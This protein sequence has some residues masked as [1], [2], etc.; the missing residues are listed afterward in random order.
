MFP[1]S[2]RENSIKLLWKKNK[3]KKG[4]ILYI[5]SIKRYI[6]IKYN[7]S[8]NIK[9]EREN[10]GAEA[11]LCTYITESSLCIFKMKEIPCNK[12]FHFV[13]RSN[14]VP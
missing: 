1:F 9:R 5:Y 11:N 4:F 7:Y 14:P 13:M 8:I 12:L 2:Y 10:I 3:I 6:K